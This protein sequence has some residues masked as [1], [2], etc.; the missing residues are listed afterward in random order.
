MSFASTLCDVTDAELARDAFERIVL[1]IAQS[2]LSVLDD[3]V[4][5]Q[6]FGGVIEQARLSIEGLRKEYEETLKAKY[7]EPIESVLARVPLAYY[8]TA[9]T[10][11]AIE[12]ARAEAERRRIAESAARAAT[13]RAEKSEG[14]LQKLEKYKKKLLMKQGKKKNKS[15]IKKK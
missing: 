11:L 2:G 3:D 15:K 14:E 4:I 10:Q 12:I 9:V 8:S 13:K 5:G 6:V 7:G 1:G